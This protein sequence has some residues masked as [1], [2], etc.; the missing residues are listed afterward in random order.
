MIYRYD[1]ASGPLSLRQMMDRLLEEAF[2]SPRGLA[3]QLGG[4]GGP[5][6]NAYE[7]GDQ[8]VVETQL[9]GMKPEDIQVSIEQGVLTIQGQTRAEEERK[10]RTYLIREHRTGRFRRGVRLPETVDPDAVQATYED[11]V[12][13][14]MLP[15]AER[16]KA[17]RIQIQAGGQKSIAGARDTEQGTRGSGRSGAAGRS[18]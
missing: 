4:A 14:L 18:S 10:E 5:A 15:K 16:A 6:L 13:R 8:F 17:R 1:P 3:G 12:L 7:E 9:P 2:V 11:G